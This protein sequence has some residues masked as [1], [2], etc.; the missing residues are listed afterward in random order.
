MKCIYSLVLN[1][2]NMAYWFSSI[3]IPFFF[4]ANYDDFLDIPLWAYYTRLLTEYTIRSRKQ[5]L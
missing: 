4:I 1:I 2:S 3:N 5:L